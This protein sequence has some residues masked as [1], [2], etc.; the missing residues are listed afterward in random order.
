MTSDR[1]HCHWFLVIGVLACIGSMATAQVRH[2]WII[3]TADFQTQAVNLKSFDGGAVVE[4]GEQT[5][6][7]IAAD[8]FLLIQRNNATS[9]RAG[10]FVVQLAGGDRAMGEPKSIEGDNLVW[11]EPV[12]GEL[13]LSLKSVLSIVKVDEPDKPSAA[14]KTEDVIILAN[15]DAM[16]GIIAGI[17]AVSISI[18]QQ[19]GETA[20]VPLESIRRITFA[21]VGPPA[22]STARGYCVTLTNGSAVTVKDVKANDRIA[23]LTLRDGNSRMAAMSAVASIEQV[24]GP[25]VWASSL[26]P[27]E[28]IQKPFLDI[29]WPARMD[30]AVDG[31]PI[32]SGQRIHSHGIGVHSYS[33]L[34][35]AIDPSWLTFRTQY[36]IPG[37]KP[38]ANVTV[39][40]KLDGQVA[41]EKKDFGAPDLSPPIV[42]GL[43]GRK[44]ITLEVDYGE[45]YDV[46]DRFNWVE[47][48]FLK[49]KPQK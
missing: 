40:I 36:C 5:D 7:R 9:V 46:Q 33:Q 42:L 20:K 3:T 43:E 22:V 2:E 38:Y 27:V 10:K 41:H 18:Q 23:T 19:G 12:L 14:S 4:A 35:F 49:F 47:P 24:N 31:E 17:D 26:T 6:R 39:R 13:T 8:Q 28:S 34:T 44:Q 15:G 11:Q 30:R 45:N 16:R 21:A 32:R 25:V 1:R 29:P 37:D 48:A